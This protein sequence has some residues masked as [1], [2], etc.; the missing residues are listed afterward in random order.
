MKRSSLISAPLTL[1]VWI[2]AAL[3][4]F[5][6]NLNFIYRD[7][8]GHTTPITSMADVDQVLPPT[9]TGADGKTIPNTAATPA[10]A[11]FEAYLKTPTSYRVKDLSF[12]LTVIVSDDVTRPEDYRGSWSSG[13]GKTIQIQTWDSYR[14]LSTLAHEIAH[15]YMRDKAGRNPTKG[16]S[17]ETKYGLDKQHYVNE[18]TTPETALSEGYA[19]YHGDRYAPLQKPINEGDPVPDSI[20]C[21]GQG[22]L[23]SFGKESSTTAGS[24]T[25]TDWKDIA[26]ADDMWASEAINAAIL[27]D[28]AAHVPQGASKIEAFITAPQ[29]EAK[30]YSTLQDI[31]KQWVAKYP[32]D[33]DSLA[34][35]IDANTNF[36]MD[37]GDLKAL[38]GA[39]NY[40]DNQRA[41][42]IANLKGQS[43]CD[44]LSKL[45]PPPASGETGSPG[46]DSLFGSGGP[47]SSSGG[48]GTGSS[49]KQPPQLKKFR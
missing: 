5:A 4:L 46:L 20:G 44:T 37:G 42:F 14:A 32:A 19:E 29:T 17:Q 27:R 7:A 49:P 47:S 31:I 26:S 36:T 1:L 28:I 33:G 10:R 43:P 11:I 34:R 16:M 18:T 38:T 23:T 24:Y 2:L 48:A 40:V 13:D 22:A 30:H 35:I 6:G 3:P 39:D 41:G 25:T 12:D 15:T 8:N 9:V 21:V 45:F